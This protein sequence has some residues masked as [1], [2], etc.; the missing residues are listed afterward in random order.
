M[1][2]TSIEFLSP[3]DGKTVVDATLGYGGHARALLERVGPT[4]RLVALDLD[5]AYFADVEPKL[6]A[7]G[8]P[9]QICRANFAGLAKTM[10]ELG[11][12]RVDRLIADLGVSSM[13]IDHADR[14]FSFMRDGP[15][16]MRMNSS[17]G[18]TAAEVIATATESELAEWFQ[19]LGDEPYAESIARAIVDRRTNRPITSTTE[20]ARLVLETVPAESSNR[21]FST[22]DR[23]RSRSFERSDERSKE[24]FD[25]RSIPI[26][27]H[28]GNRAPIARVFQS[29][30]MVVNRETANLESL[31]RVLPDCLESDGVAVFISFHSGEDRMIKRA[32]RQGSAL[33]IYRSISPEPVRPTESEAK[34]NPRSRSAKLRWAVR[35]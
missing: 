28:K 17:R 24:G 34:A 16:D 20:L 30:R 4:G 21:R 5:D 13:Q 10:G 11:L 31:L 12:N 27:I 22:R 19:E 9:Y 33:G 18:R 2:D 23:R 29:I 3:L 1:L 14:G 32:F 35:A 6:A 8:N 26:R 15:L 25:D 7:V